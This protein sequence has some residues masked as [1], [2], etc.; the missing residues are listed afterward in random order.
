MLKKIRKLLRKAINEVAKDPTLQISASQEKLQ[1]FLHRFVADEFG[2]RANYQTGD[3]GYGWLHY[4]FIRAHKPKKVLC[5]G[6]RFGY[7]PAVLAQACKDNG[8]GHVSFVDAGFGSDDEQNWTGQAFWRKKEGQQLFYHT[9][10]DNFITLFV[11]T[12][13]EFANKYAELHFDYIYIDGDHS[14]KGALSDYKLFWPL[15]NEDGFMSFH[16]ISVKET[17]V[18]GEYGVHKV[19]DMIRQK[20]HGAIE[21]SFIGSGLGIVQKKVSTASRPSKSK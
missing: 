15:L 9:Q 18:E 11:M 13:Q 8:F 14:Y 6:S 16:D 1:Q 4:S 7:I 5:V 3:L 17:L 10:L 20:H 12:T 2:H 19:W 21:F